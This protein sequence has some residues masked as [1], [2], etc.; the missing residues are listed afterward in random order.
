MNIQGQD[1]QT[2]WPLD[3]EQATLEEHQDQADN[4]HFS[5][6][7]NIHILNILEAAN[8]TR[9]LPPAHPSAAGTPSTTYTQLTQ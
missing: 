8:S 9:A 4:G 6:Y 2:V 7:T 3:R 1:A 5:L